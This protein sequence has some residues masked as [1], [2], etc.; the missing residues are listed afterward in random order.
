[1]SFLDK[2]GLARLW[3][4]ILSL[5]NTKAD[6]NH[7]NHI[8]S[9]SSSDNGKILRVVDGTATWENIPNAEGGSY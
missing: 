6:I 9:C 8:P 4:N 2:T 5:A 3:A 7:G 1:M